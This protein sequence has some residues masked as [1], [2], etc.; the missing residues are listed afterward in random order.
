M[1]QSER[2]GLVLDPSGAAFSALE[3][4]DLGGWTFRSV[5]TVDAA[6]KALSG[7]P[8]SV[9][10][11]AFYNGHVWPHGELEMLLARGEFEWI[12][13]LEEGLLRRELV[14]PTVLR[15]FHDFHSLPFDAARLAITLGHAHGKTVFCRAHGERLQGDG[16][17]GMTGSSLPMLQLYR[18]IEKVI[19]VDAPV[20][21]GGESGTGKELVSRAIH[22]NSAR[23]QGPFVAMNCGA[24]PPSLIHSELFGYERGA[25][26]GAS[27]RKIGNIEAANNGIL[28]LDEIGDLP[29][30]MQANLLRFLQE[31]T[32]TR[33]GA[34]ERIKLNVR[35]IA[36]THVDLERAVAERRF[37]EDLYYRLNVLPLRVPALR[38]QREDIPMPTV[39]PMANAWERGE[40]RQFIITERVD[41][42]LHKHQGPVH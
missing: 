30:D 4:L 13:L 31:K 5:S 39:D 25:F 24:I 6:C 34:T 11:V 20:L 37:R 8:L 10:L 14:C 23:A 38:E 15:G 33:V 35:V 3:A 42:A 29:L 17:F 19:P 28:F 12:A 7:P 2:R 26:T 36:A 27:Q 22:Q 1:P 32:I 40:L 16:R 18:Q 41:S 21:I 9:G